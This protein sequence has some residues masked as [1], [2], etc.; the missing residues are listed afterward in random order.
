MQETWFD[1]WVGKTPWR[2]EWQPNPVFL[3]VEFTKNTHN[4]QTGILKGAQYPGHQQKA[5]QN[6]SE[7][8]PHTCQNG[9]H[10]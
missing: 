3:S 4:W 6:H 7:I 10:Q 1:P 2:R 8:P 9:F 5:N